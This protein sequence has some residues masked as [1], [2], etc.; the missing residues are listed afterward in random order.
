MP[1]VR[2]NV[3]RF[4]AGKRGWSVGSAA[5]RAPASS[6]PRLLCTPCGSSWRW[7]RFLS[8][9]F[10]V[11]LLAVTAG[12]HGPW[13]SS[14]PGPG[15]PRA[16]SLRCRCLC[17]QLSSVLTANEKQEDVGCCAPRGSARTVL[18]VAACLHPA[19][20]SLSTGPTGPSVCPT[21]FPRG[22]SWERPRRA[23]CPGRCAPQRGVPGTPTGTHS[24]FPGGLPP[25]LLCSELSLTFSPS[26]ALWIYFYLYRALLICPCYHRSLLLLLSSSTAP[27]PR[28]GVWGQRGR[29]A[30]PWGHFLPGTAR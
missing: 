21:H 19:V 10:P 13:G 9:D 6:Q 30:A 29:R 1:T 20:R 28:P 15:L 8:A 27:C 14:R 2:G 12:S 26:S 3:G 16:S 18:A 23:L 25:A 22:P 24:T 11:L 5:R 7:C 17:F 4:G